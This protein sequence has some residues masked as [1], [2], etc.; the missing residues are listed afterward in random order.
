[1]PADVCGLEGQA[2]HIRLYSIC[3]QVVLVVGPLNLEDNVLKGIEFLHC[4]S[5][6]DVINDEKVSLMSL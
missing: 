3:N 5:D 2:S 6:V 1:M 4:S